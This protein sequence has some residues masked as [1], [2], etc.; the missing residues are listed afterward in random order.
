MP[1]PLDAI[2]DAFP[3]LTLHSNVF[4][5]LNLSS[6]CV[7][8]C[9]TEHFG[10]TIEYC[11]PHIIVAYM[12]ERPLPNK[13]RGLAITITIISHLGLDVPEELDI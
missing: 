9:R 11:S 6:E 8:V 3:I 5:S 12:R 2:G 1:N 10:T 4:S 13:F 7:C